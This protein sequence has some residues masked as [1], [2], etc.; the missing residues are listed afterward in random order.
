[1]LIGAS[2]GVL[3]PHA[4]TEDAVE[5]LGRGGF[6]AVEVIVQTAG[7]YR[8]AFARR[9]AAR[10][11]AAGTTVASLHT[12]TGLHPLFDPYPRRREEGRAAL[13]RAIDVA[14]TLGAR[15]VVWHGPTRRELPAGLASDRFREVLA[16][17]A[18]AGAAAGVT[19]TLE[20]VSWCLLRDAESV[21]LVR[22]WGLPVGFT[23]DP[24]QAA[25]AGVDTAALIAAMG[26]ALVNVHL[27]DH[28]PG[29]PRH[30]PPGEGTIP[31]PT[32]LGQL[33]AAG[34]AGPL[35][36]EGNCGG[37]LARLERSRR[38]VAAL[39]EGVGSP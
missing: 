22:G 3:Y 10:A 33:R 31:W 8:P 28:C 13:L 11:R 34:Y 6:V 38:F 23:F 27:S 37:D 9:L 2:T 19:L 26:D 24:F 25:E 35:I 29:G 32:V 21:R 30:L 16:D 36:L 1:M 17:V 4:L 12:Y 7:E 20:N 15:S 14:A 5:A 18:Q 39:L